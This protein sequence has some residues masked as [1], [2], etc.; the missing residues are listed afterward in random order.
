MYTI[1]YYQTLRGTSPVHEFLLELDKKTRAKARRVIDYLGEHGPN[2]VRPYADTING[3]IRELR[4]SFSH[5][6]VRILYFF[7]VRHEVVLL[8]GFLKK[9]DALD[10]NDIEMAERR[11]ADWIRRHDEEEN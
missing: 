8:H 1:L 7:F 9:T 4:I 2:L 6:N 5:N 10:P 11:M 3:K